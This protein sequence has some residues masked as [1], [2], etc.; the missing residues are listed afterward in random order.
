MAKVTKDVV[1]AIDTIIGIVWKSA[2]TLLLIFVVIFPDHVM[3]YVQ[4]IAE[5]AGY[6]ITQLTIMGQKLD[7]ISTDQQ[8]QGE[9]LLRISSAYE[10]LQAENQKMRDLLGCVSQGCSDAQVAAIATLLGTVRVADTSVQTTINEALA[11]AE[12][13]VA[14]AT[15]QPP[16][17]TGA[18]AVI[19]GSDKSLES[20]A[21]ELQ[22]LAQEF[23]AEIVRRGT[24]YATLTRFE[25]RAAADAA[26]SQITRLMGRPPIVRAFDTW[27]PAPSV[28]PEEV[29]VCS[30]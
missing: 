29:L 10:E 7:K 26:V 23:E 24:W 1:D 15:T 8:E 12:E 5:K 9:K 3:G 21:W 6:D 11:S 25:T 2:L 19:V 27:C 4:Q 28:G 13:I 18:V 22:K 30:L 20:A 16:A 17:T 14:T